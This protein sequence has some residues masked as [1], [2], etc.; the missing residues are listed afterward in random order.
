MYVRKGTPVIMYCETID[1]KCLHYLHLKKLNIYHHT[2]KT[3]Q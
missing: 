1:L 3:Y 2:L